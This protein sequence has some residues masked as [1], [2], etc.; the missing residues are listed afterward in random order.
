LAN[1]AVVV[2]DTSF[3]FPSSLSAAVDGGKEERAGLGTGDVVFDVDPD[4]DS[5][6]S[7]PLSSAGGD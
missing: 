3:F 7:F 4:L 5:C 6:S 1:R 2:N